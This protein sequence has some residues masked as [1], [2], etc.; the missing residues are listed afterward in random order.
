MQMSHFER[1]RLRYC[2]YMPLSFEFMPFFFIILSKYLDS[3]LMLKFVH[4][5]VVLSC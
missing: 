2:S 1:R 5:H 4:I 3:V